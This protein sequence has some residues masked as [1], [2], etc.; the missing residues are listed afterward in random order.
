MNDQKLLDVS[1]SVACAQFD[2]SQ[3]KVDQSRKPQ[4]WQHLREELRAI[5]RGVMA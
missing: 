3:A 4:I 1:V 2:A 5:P